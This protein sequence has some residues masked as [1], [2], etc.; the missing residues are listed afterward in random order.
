MDLDWVALADI[1]IDAEK[2]ATSRAAGHTISALL[3]RG[4]PV[5]VGA[6]VPLPEPSLHLRGDLIGDGAEFDGCVA[7]ESRNLPHHDPYAGCETV[8]SPRE[9][10]AAPVVVVS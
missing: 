6:G 1:C 8:G 10:A 9:P 3:S 2:G 5:R 7:R 4:S